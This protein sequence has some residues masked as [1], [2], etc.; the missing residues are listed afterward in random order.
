MAHYPMLSPSFYQLC[1]Y[2]F[3]HLCRLNNQHHVAW[4]LHQL[5]LSVYH[6]SLIFYRF[7]GYILLV[8]LTRYMDQYT[9]GQVK[10]NQILVLEVYQLICEYQCFHHLLAFLLFL[11]H[12]HLNLLAASQLHDNAHMMVYCDIF[13]QSLPHYH[14]DNLC[15][16]LMSFSQPCQSKIG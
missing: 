6:I 7:R 8:F 4:L 12:I 15:I 13:F 11:F 5:D 14:M 9:C 10:P 3:C 1:F 2:I 16:F